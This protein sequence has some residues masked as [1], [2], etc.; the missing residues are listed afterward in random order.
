MRTKLAIAVAAAVATLAL[1]GATAPANASV[2]SPQLTWHPGGCT[3]AAKGGFTASACDNASGF[4][5]I[6]FNSDAY[7]TA[8][9]AGC[10]W[11][12]IDV[13]DANGNRVM[14]GDWQKFCGTGHFTGPTYSG[15]KTA[16]PYF[17]ELTIVNG[18][19]SYVWDGPYLGYTW[20]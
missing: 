8:K 10:Y 18:H 1:T 13:Y 14:Q 3:K 11:L 5:G 4:G 12:E 15:S 17:S 19:D 20:N 16:Q 2:A 6:D 9:P 7:V